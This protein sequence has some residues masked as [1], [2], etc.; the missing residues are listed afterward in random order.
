MGLPSNGTANLQI[1]RQS[2]GQIYGAAEIALSSASPGLFTAGGTGTGQIA[3]LN[4]DNSLNSSSNAAAHGTVIQLFGT[5]Q[6]FVANAPPDGT[7]STGLV[8]TATT[9]LVLLNNVFVPSTNIQYT[10]LAPS[11]VGV[12][13]I[14]VLIPTTTAPGNAVSLQV[15][16]SSIP[17]GNPSSPASV[18]TTIAVK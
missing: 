14:N 7:P 13:Q 5:G 6:G 1:V 9:P 2:T 11:E 8:P 17:S 3:A 4:A 16:M 15:F 12:W 10:G 18:A